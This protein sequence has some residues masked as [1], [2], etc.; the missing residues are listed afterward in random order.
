MTDSAGGAV[1]ALQIEQ[2]RPEIGLAATRRFV[3]DR[4]VLDFG[5]KARAWT[6]SGDRTGVVA[7]GFATGG[8]ELGPGGALGRRAD[9]QVAPGTVVT[10]A[11]RRRQAGQIRQPGRA[12]GVLRRWPRW[13]EGAA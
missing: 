13:L 3:L 7:A 9:W 11:V 1:E 10:G 8:P 12:D 6:V 4:G 5:I 2:W